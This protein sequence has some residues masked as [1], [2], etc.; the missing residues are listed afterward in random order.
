[1]PNLVDIGPYVQK[2]MIQM[3][4]VYDDDNKKHQINVD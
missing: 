1:M 3:L 4:Q 2:K